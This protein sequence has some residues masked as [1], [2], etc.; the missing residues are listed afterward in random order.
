MSQSENKQFAIKIEPS[1]SI[2][3]A[4]LNETIKEVLE[5]NRTQF[6]NN[7]NGKGK[8]LS[9]RIE[10]M[11]DPPSMTELESK[12]FGT[13]SNYRMA[14]QHLVKSDIHIQL[15][16]EQTIHYEKKISEFT[17]KS[18]GVGY[19]IAVD[20]GTTSVALYL[21][22]LSTGEIIAQSIFL[23]P[24]I[25]YGG[26]VMTRIDYAK[27]VNNRNQLSGCIQKR[28]SEEIKHLIEYKRINKEDITKL[29]VA[30]NSAMSQIWLERDSGGLARAPFKSVL[31]GEGF[32][33]FNP[34]VIGLTK[35]N[36]LCLVFPILAGFVGG[37]I[38]AAIL[39]S[40]LTD[41]GVQLLIDLGTNGEVVLAVG[42]KLY[43]ASTAAGP[44]FE[45]VGMSSG[46]PAV[47]GA[48]QGF[49]NYS[50]SDIKPVVIGGGKPLGF[51]GSGYISAIA[52]LISKGIINESGLI[53]KD[54]SGERQWSANTDPE[55]P[56]F[57]TQDD[58]RKFQ[59]AKGAIAA[60]VE[61]LCN[62]AGIKFNDIDKVIL[63]G[64]FGN[65]IDPQAA[66]EIGLIPDL[67]LDR[68]HFIDNA[69]GRGAALCLSDKSL[70]E[71][72]VELQKKTEVIN[73][74]ELPEF[75]DRF[76]ANM[77]FKGMMT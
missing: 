31:E 22:D 64:S 34:E 47:T 28:V 17:I 76:V 68:V 1:G 19:G 56:P 10:Y 73:L 70:R 16:S 77:S 6:P 61:I 45:G 21:A 13:D 66:M 27:D 35:R 23:N 52:K 39:S 44:A 38:T 2:F 43:A 63:T 11:S 32:I 4:S 51:C 8:C 48:I 7:C 67:P 12:L 25:A 59:L 14:C 50:E 33:P 55:L 5:R 75:Q 72:A 60:G 62:K 18:H 65:R 69:A 41:D 71:K 54:E 46:M 29:I 37:D 15:P 58:V 49:S 53:E 3:S 9:C 30:G 57:I 42:D 24:Q 26:D 74:G 20:L 36:C 40:G